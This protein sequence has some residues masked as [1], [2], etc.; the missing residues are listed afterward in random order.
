MAVQRNALQLNAA[1]RSLGGAEHRK[2]ALPAV[3]AAAKRVPHHS[4]ARRLLY[5]RFLDARFI[6]LFFALP[7]GPV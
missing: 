1:A 3:V 6:I 7:A 5:F 4:R 2:M